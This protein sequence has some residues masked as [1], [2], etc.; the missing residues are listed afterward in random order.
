MR[1][2][3][4]LKDHKGLIFIPGLENYQQKLQKI[5]WIWHCRD[6]SKLQKNN[7]RC[8]KY[9]T[10]LLQP[11]MCNVKYRPK[12]LILICHHICLSY[13]V[14]YS[15][16]IFAVWNQEQPNK[17]F[18]DVSR[19]VWY[20]EERERKRTGVLLNVSSPTRSCQPSFSF[21][22]L[23]WICFDPFCFVLLQK[24]QLTTSV[25]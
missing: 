11:M 13:Q 24:N 8:P 18:A 6:F 4:C 10:K 23:P 1:L 14:G 2:C 22:I 16:Q 5:P 19:H 9:K 20:E 12:C 21:P 25:A 17:M 7:A 15:V 3:T